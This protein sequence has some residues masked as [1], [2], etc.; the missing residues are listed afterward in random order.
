MLTPGFYL[1]PTKTYGQVAESQDF[2][3]HNRVLS[4]GDTAL[5]SL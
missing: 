3:F 4:L 5:E 1:R 2:F